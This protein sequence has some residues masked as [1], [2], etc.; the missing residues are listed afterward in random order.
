[1]ALL[2]I[3]MYQEANFTETVTLENI[4]YIFEFKWN[5]RFSF[6][7]MSISNSSN[8]YII[9]G[10]H[11]VTG[12]ELLKGHPNIGL[13]PGKMMVTDIRQIPQDP[14]YVDFTNGNCFLIYQES[15]NA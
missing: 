14:V 2:Q 1:M 9:R 11:L 6:W 15:T 4:P 5:D 13:P 8:T 3:P 12:V 7:S 10:I